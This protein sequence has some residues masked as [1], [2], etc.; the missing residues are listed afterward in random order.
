MTN[1]PIGLRGDRLKTAREKRGFSQ[2]EFSEEMEIKQQ[3]LSR[4]ETGKQDP[5][6]NALFR[7]SQILNVSVDYL[8]GL[9]DEMNAFVQQKPIS[10]QEYKLLRA[11]DKG[12]IHEFFKAAAEAT[13]STD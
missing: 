10:P 2:E 8:L 11:F 5:S 9:V 6:G 3:Q 4:W 12:A 7:M 13:E 1:K